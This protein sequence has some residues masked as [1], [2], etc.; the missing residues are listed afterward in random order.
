MND[1]ML[2][3]DKET[4]ELRACRNQVDAMR[5]AILYD[6]LDYTPLVTPTDARAPKTLEQI[7]DEMVSQRLSNK[8]GYGENALERVNWEEEFS[9]ETEELNRL[10]VED[11]FSDMFK[12]V[13]FQKHVVE[14]P[15]E[16]PHIDTSSN[17]KAT[18][19][20]SSTD[21]MVEEVPNGES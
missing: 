19:E 6:V 18:S 17:V 7:V 21:A 16:L 15:I 3:V 2:F 20:G 5:E 12:K 1:T 4:G 8:L 14:E 10:E 11:V 13:D 9:N